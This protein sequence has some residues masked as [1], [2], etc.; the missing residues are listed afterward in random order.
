MF[1]SALLPNLKQQMI[2]RISIHYN[3]PQLYII[4][5][6]IF[7]FSLATTVVSVNPKFVAC[8]PR[9][10]GN[11]LNIK[12][13]FWIPYEQDSFCGYPHFEI[14]CKNKNPILKASNYDLLVKDI[15]YTNSSFTAA[16][17]AAYEEK[18]P[19]PMNNYSFDK[20]PFTYSSE[21]NNLTF[22]YNCTTKPIDYPIYEVDCAENASHSSFAVFHKEVL[23]RKNYSMNECQFVINV[24]LNMNAAV[25]FSSLLQMNY[26]EILKMGFLLNWTAPSCQYCEK[27]G[28]RCGFDGDQFLCFCKDKSYL[29]SC[30]DDA[31]SRRKWIVVVIVAAAVVGLFGLAMALLFYQ[32]R[33]KTSY[34]MSYTQPRSL[35][36]D[37]SSWKDTE[38]GS[39]YFGAHLFTYTELEEATNFFDPSRELGDG[40]FGTVYYGQLPDGRCIAVKRLYENNYRRVEQ[41]MNEIE[42]LT[43]LRHKNL[44]SLFGC[45]SRHSRE[46]LLVYEYIANGTVADH[47]H[48]NRAKA[49]TLPWH[50]RMNI[51][52][53]TATALAYLHDSEIIHRDV[54][55]NNILLDSNFVVKVADFG[56]SRLF[57]NNVTHVSTVPQ[58]TPGYVDPEYHECYQLTVK[59]DV[60]SFGVVLVELISSLPAVD[61]TRHRHEINLS[62][63][64]I[65]KIQNQALHE[66]VDK[67][68]GFDSDLKVRKMI[69]A[70]AELAFQCLQSSKD[71][72][73][74]MQEVV[75]TLKDIQSDGEYKGQSHAEVMDISSTADDAVLLKDDPPPPSPASTVGSKSTTPNASG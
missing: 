10:C 20:L 35:S 52:L 37:P 2:L 18:C 33:K 26:T 56:L 61:I 39:Q 15:N 46:L 19:A 64:A 51:A 1:F 48:G 30:G 55:T 42:I 7:L 24:P 73:P 60:Y 72:R 25:N 75:D 58:G 44:V 14:T 4:I 66:L 63:M 57:P 67:N 49:G 54:K 31:E 70:V 8:T 6:I 27:S 50:I 29:K 11:G 28:G 74:S 16:N 53:E 69:N 9:S 71:M 22:F 17:L 34:G 40:G 65:N 12:Y 21:N 47:L 5:T 41:F 3:G 36:S 45:T 59:S 43:R 23:E 38:K 13:P 68:L 62:T 32:R